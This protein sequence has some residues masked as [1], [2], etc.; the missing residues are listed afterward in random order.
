MSFE[1]VEFD[2]NFLGVSLY[3]VSFNF[4][5]LNK[6]KTMLFSVY[7][8]PIPKNWSAC[9]YVAFLQFVEGSVGG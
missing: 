8:P 2:F 5:L 1:S 3:F 4:I 6:M 7:N 9:E